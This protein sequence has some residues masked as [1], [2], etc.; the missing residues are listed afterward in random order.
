MWPDPVCSY[1]LL[2][3]LWNIMQRRRVTNTS[4]IVNREMA[5]SVVPFRMHRYVLSFEFLEPFD[6][7]PRFSFSFFFFY[8]FIYLFIFFFAFFFFYSFALYEKQTQSGHVHF[9][10]CPAYLMHN[11]TYHSLSIYLSMR[12]SLS[13]FLSFL[14]G[15][16]LSYSISRVRLVHGNKSTGFP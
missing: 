5:S 11:I 16:Q 10:T 9:S 7:S 2:S 4:G 14:Y 13:N 12:L 3:Y 8:L 15:H 1:T 6:G